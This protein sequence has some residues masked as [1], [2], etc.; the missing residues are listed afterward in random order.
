MRIRHRYTVLGLTVEASPC[1]LEQIWGPAHPALQGLER[2][3]LERI[4][5]GRYYIGHFQG[6]WT[7]Y[8]VSYPG[9]GA[10]RLA[11]LTRKDVEQLGES[12]QSLLAHHQRRSAAGGE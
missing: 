5:P 1:E 3:H 2:L 7:L 10:V 9:G 6:S 11:H 4:Y 12:G 8:G